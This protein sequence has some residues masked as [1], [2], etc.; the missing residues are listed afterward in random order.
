MAFNHLN[1]DYES[2]LTFNHLNNNFE[3]YLTFNHLNN[4]YESYRIF[5]KSSVINGFGFPLPTTV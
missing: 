4:D 2:Y 1:N 3:S 5:S